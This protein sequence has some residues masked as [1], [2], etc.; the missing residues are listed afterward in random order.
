MGAKV[1]QGEVIGY[2]GSTGWA[3]A[4]HLDYRIKKNGKWVNPRR[5]SLPPAKPVPDAQRAEFMENVARLDGWLQAVPEDASTLVLHVDG[6]GGPGFGA[7]I[8]ATR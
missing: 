1:R 7:G 3:T 2:V 8:G 4:P 6:A 5:M